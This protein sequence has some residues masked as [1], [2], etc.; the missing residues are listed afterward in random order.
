V[1]RLDTDPASRVRATTH[2]LAAGR[3]VAIRRGRNHHP[4]PRRPYGAGLSTFVSLGNKADVS[5]NDLL[6]D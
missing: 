3:G 2:R 1:D 5:G 6:S 4:R